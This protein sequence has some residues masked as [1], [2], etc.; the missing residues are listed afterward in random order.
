[1]LHIVSYNNNIIIANC[2][3]PIDNLLIMCYFWHCVAKSLCSV[4]TYVKSNVTIQL[5]IQ[6]YI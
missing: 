3:V 4:T 6:N 5:P 1:M 2:V